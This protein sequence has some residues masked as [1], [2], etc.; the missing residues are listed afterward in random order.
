MFNDIIKTIKATS[1]NSSKIMCSFF[2]IKCSGL[3]YQ[4]PSG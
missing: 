1:I 3:G 4:T 2:L